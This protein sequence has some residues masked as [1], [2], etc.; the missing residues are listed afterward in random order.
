MN[1]LGATG[2][3]RLLV[4]GDSV[5][6]HVFE[7]RREPFFDRV[8]ERVV[9]RE[10]GAGKDCPGDWARV[11]GG[12]PA[13]DLGLF[14][15]VS[16]GA[17]D[18]VAH[19]RLADW[20]EEGGGR[21]G[22]GHVLRRPTEGES[23]ERSGTRDG[24]GTYQDDRSVGGRQRTPLSPNHAHAHYKLIYYLGGNTHALVHGHTRRHLAEGSFHLWAAV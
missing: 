20:A 21:L 8:A 1:C 11:V 3:E 7:V 23:S 14:V 17:C 22:G 13:L 15:A 19:R 6:R 24:I 4:E 12:E 10:G 16:V 5:T 2:G 9:A 18:G